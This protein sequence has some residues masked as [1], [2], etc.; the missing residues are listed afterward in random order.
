MLVVWAAQILPVCLIQGVFAGTL[1][2]GMN[3]GGR[4]GCA[5]N[6]SLPIVFIND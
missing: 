4:L 2:R 6:E 3:W 1:E 5:A